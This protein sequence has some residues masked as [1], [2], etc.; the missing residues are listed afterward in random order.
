VQEILNE[1]TVKP[2]WSMALLTLF[3]SVALVLAAAGIFGVVS[4]LV[5]SARKRSESEW[6]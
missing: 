5:A 4:Y 2:R 1:A 6:P 3:A